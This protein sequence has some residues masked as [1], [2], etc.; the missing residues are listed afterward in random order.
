[1]IT[2]EEYRKESS[3]R[4]KKWITENKERF[5]KN[6]RKYNEKNKEKILQQK[7]QYRE[8]NKE[9]I[10]QYKNEKI[11]CECGVYT[12]RSSIARHRKSKKH[13]KLLQQQNQ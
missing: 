8:N 2:K 3:E 12:N 5:I 11:K 6:M 10:K 13:L 1:M 9:K 4:S 7:K